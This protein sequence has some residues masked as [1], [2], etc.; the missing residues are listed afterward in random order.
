M[1][2]T[3]VL[4]FSG[5]RPG[6]EETQPRVGPLQAGRVSMLL[7]WERGEREHFGFT[8]HNPFPHT[9]RYWLCTCFFICHLP[10]SPLV[11]IYVV[12]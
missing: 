7:S 12:A 1:R 6:V 4:L 9:V 2:A 10:A 8:C 11:D 3:D 5:G